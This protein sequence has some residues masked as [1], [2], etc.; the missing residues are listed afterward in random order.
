M[1]KT[2]T[3]AYRVILVHDCMYST[4]MAWDYKRDG[5]PSAF[6]L[7]RLVQGFETSYAPGGT[8]AHLA[9]AI[10]RVPVVLSA[11]V[12]RNVFGGETIATYTKGA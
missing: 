9:T 7:L 3:P 8:N 1:G 10:G 4:P 2:V 5:R 11:R 6:N 12:E